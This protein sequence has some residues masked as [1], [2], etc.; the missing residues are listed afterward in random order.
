MPGNIIV[1]QRG[2]KFH[3]GQHV[4]IGR[5][6]TLVAL[7]P[8]YICFYEHEIPY[9]HQR[10]S[11]LQPA[12]AKEVSKIGE[13]DTGERVTRKPEQAKEFPMVK[14]PR[15]LK[16]YVGIVRHKDEVLPRDERE[17]GRERWFWQ[18]DGKDEVPWAGGQGQAR[19]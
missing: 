5:D 18:T 10:E 7:Q 3:P 2:T 12:K 13:P 16:R 4:G 8:G 9:P 17:E 11:K 6:H 14:F 19:S 1:R 15:G